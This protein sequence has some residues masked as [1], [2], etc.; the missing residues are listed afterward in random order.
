[1]SHAADSGDGDERDERDE[2]DGDERTRCAEWTPELYDE[3]RALAGRYFGA[4]RRPDT[5]QPTALVH[6]AWIRLSRHDSTRWADETHFRNVAALAMRQVL[7]DRARGRAVHRRRVGPR[8]PL[9]GLGESYEAREVVWIELVDAVEQLR[10]LNPRHAEVVTL[11]FFG[12]LT[13][14]EVAEALELSKRTVESD[15]R[16]ARAWLL[17]ELGEAADGRP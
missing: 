9:T 15:W 6:E 2:R 10:R 14:S 12:G 3:L 13:V 4:R 7:I 8:V 11:R 1:M 17:S 16:M 5:M